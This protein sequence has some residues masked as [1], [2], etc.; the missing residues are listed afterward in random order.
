MAWPANKLV[1]A[2]M[3]MCADIV[4]P[5]WILASSSAVRPNMIPHFQYPG[6]RIWGLCCV[7]DERCC[8]DG[9]RTDDRFA[10]RAPLIFHGERILR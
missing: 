1:V 3:M 8:S 2:G 10:P 9:A 5:N 4:K 6:S 7:E